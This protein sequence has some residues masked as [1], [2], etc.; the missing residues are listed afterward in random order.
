MYIPDVSDTVLTQWKCKD[1]FV[2]RLMCFAINAQMYLISAG[3]L[4]GKRPRANAEF[5]KK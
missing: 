2:S 4:G 1:E 3:S 5:S